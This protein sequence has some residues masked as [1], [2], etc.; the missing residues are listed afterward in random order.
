MAKAKK[1]T[2]GKGMVDL[3][4]KQLGKGY[5]KYCKAFGKDTSWCQIFIWWLFD[6]KGI[7]YIKNSFAR[8]AARW[9]AKH[10]TRVAMKDA[11]AGD[12]VFFTNKKGKGGDKSNGNW[13]DVSHVGLIRKQSA[14]I[15]DKKKKGKKVLVCYT[16]EGNV[17]GHGNWKKSEVANKTRR[18]SYVWAVF[19]PPYKSK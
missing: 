5:K 16:I 4:K 15:K 2:T 1:S 6:T 17:N 3:A 13:R 7:K 8:K 11:K 9:C 18:K 19:R 12:V 14:T 10:W